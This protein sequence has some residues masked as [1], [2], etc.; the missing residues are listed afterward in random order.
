[1]KLRKDGSQGTP[2]EVRYTYFK[3][4]GRMALI[5]FVGFTFFFFISSI[6]LLFLTRPD[7]EVK[8]PGVVGKQ[9][10][11]V[12]N[13]LMRKGLKPEI[14]FRDIYEIDNGTVL[15]QDPEAGEIVYEGRRVVLV[16]SRSKL[17][18]DVPNLAGM[19]LPF[20]LNKLK[21]LHIHD[22]TLTIGAGVISYVPSDKTADNIVIDQSPKPGEKI[23]PDRRIN[24]LVSAGRTEGD[25]KMPDVTGQSVN[26]CIDLLLSKGMQ[27]DQEVVETGQPEKSGIIE[28]QNPAKA[29]EI[30]RGDVAKLK[31]A[32]FKRKER[33][34]N[35]YERV[36]FTVPRTIKTGLLEA[37]VE[38]NATK[39]IAFSKVME[40]G[41][42]IDFV[43]F[44]SGD[45]RVSIVQD[46]KVIK[47][48]K[49][50]AD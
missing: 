50:D 17:I 27:I 37:Y 3:S 49:V 11:E 23:M 20:A 26:L 47:V 44:R 21:N 31:I 48:I 6:V 14:K 12:Y 1:M 7:K 25:M 13:S 32:H 46:K 9:F 41:Q 29:A 34:Y 28:A 22:R 45:S 24:L 19:E 16:V 42:K 38:D 33:E 4:V 39:R 36:E 2:P 40:P 10:N 8:V 43:F 5:F 18:L 30:K 35:A 15:E